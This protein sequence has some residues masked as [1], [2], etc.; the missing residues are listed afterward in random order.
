FRRVL[1][2]SCLCL[3]R[4]GRP[5]GIALAAVCG[6]GRRGLLDGSA[7]RC[8]H[9]GTITTGR[10]PSRG[11]AGVIRGR[12]GP[13]TDPIGAWARRATFRGS[14]CVLPGDW[15]RDMGVAE[16]AKRRLGTSSRGRFEAFLGVGQTLPTAPV[17][18][19]DHLLSP[20]SRGF[21]PLGGKFS[22]TSKKNPP[23]GNE[24]GAHCVESVRVIGA[25]VHSLACQ[26]FGDG[27]P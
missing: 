22:A 8:G 9:R 27:W 14:V 5:G 26:P 18:G 24:L 17:S 7:H 6:P 20:Y 4:R 3:G 1:F 23:T 19:V 11:C 21:L 25:S 16:P 10:P 2:R 12:T 13:N 15:V